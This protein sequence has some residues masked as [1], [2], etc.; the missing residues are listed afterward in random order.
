VAGTPGAAH[1]NGAFP[2]SEGIL[3]PADRPDQLLLATNFGLFTSDDA[4]K[5]WAWSCRM[6]GLTSET[7]TGFCP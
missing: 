7:G 5:T 6:S 4:G 2:D 3:L 1:G